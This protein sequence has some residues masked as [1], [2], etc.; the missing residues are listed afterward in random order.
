MLRNWI[1]WQTAITKSHNILMQQVMHKA[2][3]GWTFRNNWSNA[4]FEALNSVT[5]FVQLVSKWVAWLANKVR[6]WRIVGRVGCKRNP[7][8]P[9]VCETS[10]ISPVPSAWTKSNLIL[11]LNPADYNIHCKANTITARPTLCYLKKS[12]C[13][14]SDTKDRF[15]LG[16]F[17]RAKRLS[18]VKIE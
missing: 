8:P 17:F 12:R 15:P 5:S 2:E 7:P 1:P 13:Q 14:S 9:G 6:P 10:C 4:A 11:L 16:D 18:I 3:W